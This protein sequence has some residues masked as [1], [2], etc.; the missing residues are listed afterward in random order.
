MNRVALILAL[1]LSGCAGPNPVER[2]LAEHAAAVREAERAV[3]QGLLLS[4][5]PKES[6]VLLDGVL[7]GSCAELRGQVIGLE[8]GLHRV[9]IQ[10]PGFAPYRAE[11]AAGRARTALEVMLVPSR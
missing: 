9:E 5:A 11:I 7:Q 10:R 1:L 3:P 6:E 2:A 4:C 8:E